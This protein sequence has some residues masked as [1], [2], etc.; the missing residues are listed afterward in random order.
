MN[1]EGRLPTENLQ[2]DIVSSQAVIGRD[3]SL[4]STR[5][6][7]RQSAEFDLLLRCCGNGLDVANSLSR[8]L[9]WDRVFK[10]AEHHRL[11][12]ALFSA[13]RDRRDVP[14]SIQS[15]IRARFHRHSYRVLHFTA[16]LARVTRHLAENGISVLAHK[17]PA[18]AQFLYGDSVM[19]QFGDLDV[20]IAPRDFLKARTALEK[21]GYKSR[22][23]LTARQEK[24]YLRSGY[25][26]VFGL[27]EEANLLEVQ[28]RIVPRF[29]SIEFDMDSLFARSIEL[30]FEGSLV[31]TLG[32]EYLMLVLC[33]H[34]AKHQWSQLG[35][36][37]DIAALAK[38]QLD[39]QRVANEAKRLGIARI[40]SVCLLLA[41]E[42]MNCPVPSTVESNDLAQRITA[43]AAL[44][45]ESCTEVNPESIRYFLAETQLRE[46]WRDR[47]RLMWRLATTP[48]VGEWESISL[49]D[50]FFPLYRGVRIWR[51]AKRLIGSRARGAGRARLNSSAL[52]G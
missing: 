1:G 24:E 46:R 19:R 42:L 25:E 23:K 33:V 32:P 35:M 9:N 47:A 20:L 31:R 13:V 30:E 11:L 41:R 10:L 6:T 14:G 45:L 29:Y 37:R 27:G 22:L 18:L 4:S 16:E 49:S 17:G 51:L 44:R 36:I 28:W 50:K 39:W 21:L 5:L 38:Q 34:A 26:C 52:N 8:Q 43:D 40:V 15:A 48:S 3:F 7:E 12:P 2:A